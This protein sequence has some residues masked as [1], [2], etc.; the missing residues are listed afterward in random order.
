MA[1]VARPRFTP[2]VAPPGWVRLS[3]PPPATLWAAVEALP[4]D[5]PGQF[6]ANL[7]LTC[8]DTSLM[9]FR[10]WQVATDEVLPRTLTDYLV[11]DLERLE[12]DGCQGGRRLAHH[13]DG[14]GRPLTME[15]WFT[16]QGE[17]GWSLTAT[18]ETWRYDE[19]A[20]L[21]A[22]AAASWR[23]VTGGAS[24]AN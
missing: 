22:H 8:D 13:L 5:A 21:F 9:G 24:D 19:L 2:P 3:Q 10:D 11:V 16:Q 4:E 7:V 12:I 23:P 17:R 18:V 20:D 14:V 15:Q 6:R 1:E